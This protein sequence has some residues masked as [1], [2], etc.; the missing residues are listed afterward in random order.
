[1]ILRSAAVTALF[2]AAAI[3]QIPVSVRCTPTDGSAAGCYYCPGFETV[4]KWN[5]VQMHSSSANLV[6]F[7]DLDVV[8]HGTWNG[9]VIEVTSIQTD[10]ESFSISGNGHL[11][12]RF[13]YNTVAAPGALA[14]NLAALGAAFAVP[15]G[16]LALQLDPLSAVMLGGGAVDS[17]GEFT[18]DLDIPDDPS[19]IGLRV[20]GQGVVLDAAAGIYTTNLDTKVVG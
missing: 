3:A 5:G 18:S 19:L 13:R 15:F 7:H 6:A 20:Y 16:D 10:F 9:T 4:I 1:M 12:N 14:I 17:A 2:T 8:V 11:G